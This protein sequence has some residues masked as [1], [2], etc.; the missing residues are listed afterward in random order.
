MENLTKQQAVNLII[1]LCKK[2]NVIVT[3]GDLCDSEVID[4]VTEDF[5]AEV[6]QFFI[7]EDFQTKM[8]N[9][10]AWRYQI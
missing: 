7:E 10:N 1:E 5:C 8:E 9:K 3:E 2:E 6:A 4:G